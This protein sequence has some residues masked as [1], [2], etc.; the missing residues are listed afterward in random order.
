MTRTIIVNLS[1]FVILWILIFLFE[2]LFVMK[3]RIKGKSK[4]KSIDQVME[5]IYL[6]GRFK[7]DKNKV[8][9]NKMAKW[10]SIINGFIIS[11]VVTVIS[12]I[13]LYIVWQLLIG[14]VLLFALIYSLYEI[15]GRHLAKKWG[16]KNE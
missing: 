14:F 15:Y 13:D 16:L 12:N 8:V 6:I 11:A 5:F 2:Y 1:F 9:Y 10:C 7:L 3:K 4:K